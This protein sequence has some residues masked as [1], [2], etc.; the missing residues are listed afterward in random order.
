MN[1]LKCL[2]PAILIFAAFINAPAQTEAKQT[3]EPTYEILLQ[4]VVASD[5]AS[6]REKLPA[7]LGPAVN[8]LK[9][10]Y[11]FSDYRLTT[12][13]LQRTSGTVEYK[14][15]LNDFGQNPN[16]PIFSEWSL[17][18]LRRLPN[19][20][21]RSAI[22]FDGFRFGARVPVVTQFVKDDA[23]SSPIVNYESVGITSTRF[24]LG[25]NEPTVIGSLATSKPGELMFLVLTVRA[26]EL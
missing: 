24:S 8:K 22:Q 19:E 5:E 18:N 20:Q 23:K 21:G 11:A 4:I 14:S 1:K 26:A 25:E 13:F 7:S 3:I 9:N 16:T 6:G 10:L 15:V 2:L 17:R 12:T